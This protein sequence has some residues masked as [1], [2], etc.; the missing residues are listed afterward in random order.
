M[1]DR[2]LAEQ[3]AKLI[4]ELESHV[5]VLFAELDW[6]GLRCTVT[7]P[8]GVDPRGFRRAAAAVFAVVSGV[9]WVRVKQR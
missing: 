9:W 1:A 6:W 7:V 5:P 2:R 4:F 3:K 8:K